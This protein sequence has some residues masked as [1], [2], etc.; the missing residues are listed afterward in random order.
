MNKELDVSLFS[1]AFPS[2]QK[3]K[4][5]KE[6]GGEEEKKE[7]PTTEI[8]LLGEKVSI[9]ECI[10]SKMQQLQITTK[11]SMS[12]QRK[13][14]S[15]TTLK[16]TDK[17]MFDEI[18]KDGLVDLVEFVRNCPVSGRQLEQLCGKCES[19]DIKYFLTNKG[20]YV[21]STRVNET[22]VVMNLS[23]TYKRTSHVSTRKYFDVFSRGSLYEHMLD[24]G[25]KL[26]L[27][28]AQLRFFQFV[29]QT[30][31]HKFVLENMSRTDVR[32]NSRKKSRTS[33]T[34]PHTQ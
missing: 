9:P 29:R 27:S 32:G 15:T 12:R 11:I 26:T 14:V 18:C 20:E 1:F 6:E 5:P 28:I 19:M 3:T 21:G 24:D 10:V 22:D 25:R 16:G 8:E 17:E 7:V 2:Q 31:M 33:E 13:T 4:P 23:K 30:Q 34:V